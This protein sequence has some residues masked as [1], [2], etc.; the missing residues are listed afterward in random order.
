[1]CSMQVRV[2][3]LCQVE[4]DFLDPENK[5]R[6]GGEFLENLYK[7]VI[8]PQLA[9]TQD[10]LTHPILTENIYERAAGYMEHLHV[11]MQQA[12]VDIGQS[13][14]DDA[15][16]KAEAE[17]EDAN[18]VLLMIQGFGEDCRSVAKLLRRC[19]AMEAMK[20]H[21]IAAGSACGCADA[22]KIVV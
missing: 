16:A 20:R 7:Q 21:S 18:D 6:V 5:N 3:E 4:K 2:S 8:A 10:A 1:M 13:I 22:V 17:D 15:A 9:L 14:S 12:V 19:G 11:D